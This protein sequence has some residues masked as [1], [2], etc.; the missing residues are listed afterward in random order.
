MG[1]NNPDISWGE[2]ERRLSG[3]PH[4]GRLVDPLAGDGSDSPAWSRKRAPY[5]APDTGRCT[6]RVPYAELHCH[7]N[8]SFLDGASHPE[9]LAEEATRLG[10]EALA[11]TDHNGFYGVVRFAEAARAVDLPTIFGAELT[12]AE[13]GRA[14]ERPGPADPAG[15]HLVILARN[16]RGYALLGRAISEGQL[17]GEKGAPR[18]PYERL[19]ELGGQGTGDHWA[20]LTACR[21]GPVPAALMTDGPVAA[22]HE[23]ARLVSDFGRSNVFVE[24]WD[25]GL[26][27]DSVRNDAMA[28]LAVQVGVDI[29]ATGNV[30]HHSVARKRLASAMAA[31]RARRSLDE[32]DG[33]LPPA[34]MH[35]RS[36]EEQAFRFR[37]YPGVVQRAYELGMDCAFD[38]S[39]VAPNLP[40]YPCP[41]GFDEMRYLRRLV[42]EGGTRRYGPRSAERVEGAWAQLDRELDLIDELGFPG[43]F[44]VVWDIVDFCRR[45]DILCQGR[46]SAANSAV[47]FALG[48]T[49]ADAVSLGLLF[50]RFLSPERDGPPDIDIDIESDRRE[51]VIQYVYDRNGRH[52]T[53]QVANV[54]TYRSKSAIR[55][56]AKALGYAQGQQDAFSTQVD[57][58]RDVLSGAIEDDAAI[59]L[60]VV[61]LAAEIEHFPRHLGIHS[62]GMVM[63]DRPMIEVCPVEWGRMEDRS[64]LQWDKDD[65]AAAGLVKFDLLGLGMLSVLHYATDLIAEHHG[66]EIDLATLPQESCVYDMLQ[67]AD[68]IGVFQIESRAQMATLPRLK[69]RTFYDLVV[70]VA[71]IRPGPIQGGSVH[72]YIRRRNG[73]EP[74]TYLHPLLENALAKTLGVPLFQEQLMQIAIDVANFTPADA[75]MLRQAMGSKRSRE[76]MDDLKAR[77]FDGMRNNGITDDIGEQIW[78]KLAAFSNYGFPESHSVSFSYLVYASSWIK[79]HYPAAFCAALLKAQPMGFWSP[80]TLVGDARRHGVVVR[81]P[82]LNLS[83]ATATLE[84]CEDSTGEVAVRL[85]FDYVRG[86][87]L[88]LAEEVDAA[89]PFASVEDLRRRVPSL[90]LAH[91]EALATAGAFGCFDIDRRSALWAAGAMSQT[92][93][94]RLPGIV[95]GVEAPTL[96]GMSPEELSHAD[97]WATGVAPD[98]HPTAFIRS[99]LTKRGVVTATDLA[100]VASGERVLVG[101][102][103]THRQRPATAQG[104]A[105]LNLEDETGLVNVVVSKGCWQRY[106]QIAKGAPALLIRGRLEKE[107]GV[108]NVVA[109]K[110]EPLPIGIAPA[111]RDFR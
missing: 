71:L 100:D 73:L 69:P 101:G 109:D 50:E 88:D 44:L 5:I 10:L 76:R 30:H 54:I 81:T 22:R 48:I 12:L 40:P 60:P 72:P 111:S 103:V 68:S 106:K 93:A 77:F 23:L 70:E 24:L 55:D 74:V 94:D 21:K 28:E 87:G 13:P 31:V 58:W 3:R 18:I 75:D 108:I 52:H 32:I 98:G 26:P 2:L 79:Y 6:G 95:T 27:M 84:P 57:R 66:I 43:Y 105:F 67:K 47:C 17:A 39:L 49:N 96:P 110:L 38:L 65:C 104:T 107:E 33:W 53:A 20:V 92:S 1:F 91:L 51:E 89:R 63:C 83:A 8:F 4:D 37:R 62:G 80:H 14:L 45:A 34:G 82:D 29:I 41:D 35:L 85:G 59:P 90:S 64:V 25:H 46:G 56:M 19:V 9:E 99:D 42:E 61:E 78:L 15:R 36:G 102:V 11:L 97:L 7:S 86:I 16:P